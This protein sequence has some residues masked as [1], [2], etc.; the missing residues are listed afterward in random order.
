MKKNINRLVCERECASSMCI[1]CV[2]VTVCVC[3]CVCDLCLCRVTEES[4]A[5]KD[6]KDPQERGVYKEIPVQ[7]EETDNL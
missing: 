3:V 7:L 2:R 6:H 5:N 1:Y 4:E